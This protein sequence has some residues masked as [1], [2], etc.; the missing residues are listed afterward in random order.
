MNLKFIT[1]AHHWQH[2]LFLMYAVCPTHVFLIPL[3]FNKLNNRRWKLQIYDAPSYTYNDCITDRFIYFLVST[4]QNEFLHYNDFPSVLLHNY[5]ITWKINKYVQILTLKLTSSVKN[6]CFK[7]N[8]I[9][10]HTMLKTTPSISMIHS[11]FGCAVAFT[12]IVWEY[13]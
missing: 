3:W 9:I 12:F 8:T 11:H 10:H 2:T 13:L 4:S 5:L 7:L 6:R 1:K